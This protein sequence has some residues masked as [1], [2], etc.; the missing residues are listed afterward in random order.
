LSRSDVRCGVVGQ[1]ATEQLALDSL[2][3]DLLLRQPVGVAGAGSARSGVVLLEWL[4]E[5]KPQQ[6]EVKVK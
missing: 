3:L 5:E 1:L 4:G 2:G 6:S